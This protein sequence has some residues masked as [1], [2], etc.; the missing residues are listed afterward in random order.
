MPT[1]P[2]SV[3]R[4]RTGATTVVFDQLGFPTYHSIA[5]GRLPH[6]SLTTRRKAWRPLKK[7]CSEFIRFR[8]DSAAVPL[9]GLFLSLSSQI[10]QENLGVFESLDLEPVFFADSGSISCI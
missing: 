8:R 9:A 10:E 2:V 4:A 5:T 1:G 7:D 3:A 6:P